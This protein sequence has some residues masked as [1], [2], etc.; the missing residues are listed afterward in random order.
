M[1]E[2]ARLVGGRLEVH[3]GNG[4][5]TRLKVELPPCKVAS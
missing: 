3:T 5:G 2:R 4:R 1:A